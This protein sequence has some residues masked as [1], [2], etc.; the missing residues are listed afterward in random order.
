MYN[1]NSYWQFSLL[2]V[3][4]ACIFHSLLHVVIVNNH[5]LYRFNVVMID[6]D[7]RRLNHINLVLCGSQSLLGGLAGGNNDSLLK[8]PSLHLLFFVASSVHYATIP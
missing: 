3:Q 4:C 7:F 6:I 5:A 8:L 1:I 2:I